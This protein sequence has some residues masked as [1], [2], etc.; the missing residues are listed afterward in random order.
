MSPSK[1]LLFGEYSILMGSQALAIPFNHFSGSLIFDHSNIINS[2][3]NQLKALQQYFEKNYQYLS[4]LNLEKFEYDVNHGL[5]FNSNIPVQYGLGSSA[6][7]TA[8]LYKCY[9]KNK[10]TDLLKIKEQ[11]AL[12]ESHMHGKS[13]GFDPLV[14]YL[15][16]AVWFQNNTIS[17]T[18]LTDQ[19][20]KPFHIF[21]VD[22]KIK[23][24]TRSFVSDFIKKFNASTQL[25]HGVLDYY[26]AAMNNLISLIVNNNS[27]LFFDK[28]F[29]FS[30][31]QLQLFNN[32]FVDSIK[33]IALQG[34][35]Q[36]LFAL[37]LCGSGGGGYYLG[38]TPFQNKTEQ[39]LKDQQF[40]YIFLA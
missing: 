28:I 22:S 38:F 36:K 9:A 4:F 14:C 2:S 17:V 32:L 16:Q 31:L 24:P 12:I 29:D 15:Q 3:N 27:E 7:L 8:E 39:F 1:I 21:L 30:N 19:S 20:L 34:L 40:D 37:K 11:L 25:T 35:E 23:A 6:A 18:D 10:E 5:C 26:I 13:S 33:P